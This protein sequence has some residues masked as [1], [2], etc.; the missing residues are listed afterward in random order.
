MSVCAHVG[1]LLVCTGSIVTTSAHL[2]V[3]RVNGARSKGT[4]ATH[5][6]V[7]SRNR[8]ALIVIRQ[9]LGGDARPF[10]CE[11]DLRMLGAGSQGECC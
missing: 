4:L 7:A 3:G 10:P 5:R 8:I 2:L 11:A 1:H 9:R 6:S